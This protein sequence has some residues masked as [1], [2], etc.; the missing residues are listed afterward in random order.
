MSETRTA[1]GRPKGSGLDDRSRLRAVA[2]LMAGNPALKTTTAIKS[3]GISDPSTIRRLRDKYQHLKDE[4]MAEV[5]PKGGAAKPIRAVAPR[6]APARPVSV[7]KNQSLQELPKVET[8]PSVAPAHHAASA[9]TAVVTHP[10]AWMA[11]WYG[12]GFESLNH[13]VALQISFVEKMMRMPHVASVLRGQL[14]LNEMALALCPIAPSLPR[15]L[16]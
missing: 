1:R 6:T 7:L 3:T 15:T 2:E 9:P 16:H 11:M 12:M 5:S 13:A 14:A 8:G 4:L 10:A